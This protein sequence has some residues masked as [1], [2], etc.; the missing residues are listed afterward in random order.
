MKRRST[1]SS[2]TNQKHCVDEISRIGATPK[3][4]PQKFLLVLTAVKYFAQVIFFSFL[5]FT[6]TVVFIS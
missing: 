2:Q 4:A 6:Y 1:K 5:R 3:K